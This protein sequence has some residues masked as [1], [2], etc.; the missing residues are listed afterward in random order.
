M[1]D[2][3]WEDCDES[4]TIDSTVPHLP[5]ITGVAPPGTVVTSGEFGRFIGTK[6]DIADVRPKQVQVFLAGA[7]PITRT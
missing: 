3:D 2:F 4:S 5:E 1:A 6:A 7:G